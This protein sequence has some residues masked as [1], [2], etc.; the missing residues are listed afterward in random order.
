M[1]TTGALLCT[2]VREG[3][4]VRAAA[5]QASGR[6]LGLT[7]AVVGQVVHGGEGQQ[8]EADVVHERHECHY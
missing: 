5:R 4:S 6:P 7:L 1:G 3:A 2:T 8:A